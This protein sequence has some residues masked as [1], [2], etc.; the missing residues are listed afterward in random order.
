M[1]RSKY[2]ELAYT[3]KALESKIFL[4]ASL[5]QIETVQSFLQV[6]L[7]KAKLEDQLSLIAGWNDG[8]LQLKDHDSD[9]Q[10]NKV[11]IIICAQNEIPN[12]PHVEK[13]FIALIS[14]KFNHLRFMK[15]IEYLPIVNNH[16]P[17]DPYS[18][19]STTI[20]SEGTET[21][22]KTIKVKDLKF[23]VSRYGSDEYGRSIKLA[24]YTNEIIDTLLK[25]SSEEDHWIP[26][27]NLFYLLDLVFGEYYMTKYITTINFFPAMIMP[28]DTNFLTAQEAKEHIDI[29]LKLEHRLCSV[30]NIPEYRTKLD[31]FNLCVNCK[32][33]TKKLE[34]KKLI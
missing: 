26:D 21:K 11:N 18:E 13:V 28:A 19:L 7:R 10:K 16:Q 6:A 20:I 24:V 30:C 15:F 3:L 22:S 2:A 4:H 8:C 1:E 31:S 29:L 17:T 25:P 14:L 27:S 12:L 9:I 34:T 5:K 32:D 33:N 23:H